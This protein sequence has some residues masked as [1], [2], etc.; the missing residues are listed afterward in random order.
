MS[1]NSEAQKSGSHPGLLL[2]SAGWYDVLV[3][4]FTFGRERSFRESLLRPAQ[5]QEG[6]T[7]LD[8]GCGTGS[9]A[10]LAKEKVGPGQV[11]GIDASP[12]MIARARRKAARAGADVAFAVAPAQALPFDDNSIDV[13]LSTLMLH[14]LPRPSRDELAKEIRRVLKPGGRVLAVDF[15]TS[16]RQVARFFGHFIPSHGATSMQDIA[17]PLAAAGLEVLVSR[18]LGTKDLHYVVARSPGGE[19]DWQ[20]LVDVDADDQKGERR[21]RL[22]VALLILASI[23]FVAVH[24]GAAAWLVGEASRLSNRAVVVAVAA[25]GAI[26]AI[27]AAYLAWLRRRTG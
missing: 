15:A 21:A 13:A 24:V 23:I 11:F 16:T 9:L 5:L 8:I 25:I 14:H 10:L 4:F 2:H 18:P 19:R 27:K 17:G 7:V 6:E 3:K 1:S 12:E 20:D 26:V 22:H